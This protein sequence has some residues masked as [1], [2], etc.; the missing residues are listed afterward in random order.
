MKENTCPKCSGELIER[1]D[2]YYFRGQLFSGAYCKVCNSLWSQ[3][4]GWNEFID[5]AKVK[6]SN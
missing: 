5:A 4:K 6:E 1:E 3:G 2:S